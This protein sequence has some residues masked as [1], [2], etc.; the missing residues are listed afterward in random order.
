MLYDR[1]SGDDMWKILGIEPTDDI[2]KIKAAYERLAS[3]IDPDESPEKYKLLCDAYKGACMYAMRK[4]GI[5]S[6]KRIQPYSELKKEYSEYNNI[7]V[8]IDETKVK[9][10][11]AKVAAQKALAEYYDAS[12]YIVLKESGHTYESAV[13]TMT[14]RIKGLLNVSSMRNDINCWHRALSSRE[15]SAI[16]GDDRFRMKAARLLSKEPLV[17][18]VAS[19]ISESFGYGSYCVPYRRF[20]LM[21]IKIPKC[22][23]SALSRPRPHSGEQKSDILRRIFIILLVVVFIVQLMLMP[24]LIRLM[25]VS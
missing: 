13:E 18:E 7:V 8:M 16:N 5:A 14:G 11:L 9:T 2:G 21:K 6:I 23:G 3:G 25:S 24:A 4:N 19:Y 12:P 22:G 15:F 1:V 17:P 10:E 20:G